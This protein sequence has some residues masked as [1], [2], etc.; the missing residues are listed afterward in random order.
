LEETVSPVAIEI[1]KQR[2]FL[3]EVM[4]RHEP[5]LQLTDELFRVY[6]MLKESEGFAREEEIKLITGF[7]GEKERN[8]FDDLDTE[9]LYDV[10]DDDD[11]YF[12]DQYFDDED[13]DDD[14][15]SDD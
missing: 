3:F 13:D 8:N 1:L 12:D 11:E 10:E 2:G 5:Q 15:Y 6:L 14:D 9:Q 4:N 7:D